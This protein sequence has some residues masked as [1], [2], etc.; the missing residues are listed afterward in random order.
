MYPVIKKYYFY[1][2]YSKQLNRYYIG[3]TNNLEERVRKHNTKHKGYTGIVNDWQVVYSEIY[4]AKSDA[5]R[6][7]REVK[8]RKSRSQIEKLIAGSEHPD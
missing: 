8:A 2:L 1:L 7:E 6:R 3:H 4:Y 5:Y